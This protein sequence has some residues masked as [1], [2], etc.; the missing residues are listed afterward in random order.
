MPHRMLCHRFV[1]KVIS[2]IR[3]VA[4]V[5]SELAARLD[6]MTARGDVDDHRARGGAGIP[7]PNHRSHVRCRRHCRK[8]LT[9]HSGAIGVPV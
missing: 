1:T 8:R 9:R 5:D 2:A 3:A 7:V 6:G 4:G